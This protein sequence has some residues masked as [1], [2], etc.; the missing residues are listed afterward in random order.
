MPLR[1]SGGRIQKPG[2]WSEGAEVSCQESAWA[3]IS[4]LLVSAI[5]I[6]DSHFFL[7]ICH[8]RFLLRLP[9]ALVMV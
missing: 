7:H 3:E 9:I 1:E 8:F 2:D 5:W 4:L 6:L